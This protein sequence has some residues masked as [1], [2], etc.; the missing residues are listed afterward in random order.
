[1]PSETAAVRLFQL[2]LKTRTG[3][4]LNVL[5]GK[6]KALKKYCDRLLAKINN[7]RGS[8]Y[9]EMRNNIGLLI[10]NEK[11]RDIYAA[12]LLSRANKISDVFI[13]G[14][15]G[16]GKSHLLYK[17]AEEAI[18]TCTETNTYRIPILIELYKDGYK[19]IEDNFIQFITYPIFHLLYPEEQY[20]DSFTRIAYENW[21]QDL[22]NQGRLII[23]IDNYDEVVGTNNI[24]I[25]L[26]NLSNAN[27]SLKEYKNTII[28]STKP[29]AINYGSGYL[30]GF[31]R[32]TL[33]ELSREEIIK[34]INSGTH[35]DEN[36]IRKLLED[37][38]NIANLAKLPLALELIRE[39]MCE[40]ILASELQS[41]GKALLEYF[42]S[43]RNIG[44]LVDNSL[45]RRI[46]KLMLPD[47]ADRIAWDF[48]SEIAMVFA[49]SRIH[50]WDS[51]VRNNKI[52]EIESTYKKKNEQIS[53]HLFDKHNILIRNSTPLR[54]SYDVY[55][56]Y[57][58]AHGLLMTGVKPD[59]VKKYFEYP[60]NESLVFL[61]GLF[62]EKH[63]FK[64][65]L[66]LIIETTNELLITEC[67]LASNFHE[68]YEHYVL[69]KILERIGAEFYHFQCLDALRKLGNQAIEFI[70]AR[71][72]GASNNEKRRIA[73]FLGLSGNLIYDNIISDLRGDDVHLKYHI[74]RVIG[75]F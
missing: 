72:D 45:R 13:S 17:M 70:K 18:N 47:G 29:F 41:S 60:N 61:S 2:L 33:A 39:K 9:C 15:S 55:E 54:F 31:K 30:K 5:F 44:E 27:Y 22:F 59:D 68:E 4:A 7:Q 21:I 65:F 35:L 56:K 63:E 62:R 52:E 73:Y 28:I 40:V 37:L 11:N 64:N 42:S 6:K 14:H 48:L 67:L 57:L 38:P 50:N 32:F 3:R 49:D 26:Q 23:L 75:D 58:V 36:S 46:A 66:D 10:D 43:L 53:V 24:E 74:I 20:L 69:Q 12:D 34:Y 16:R 8:N 19:G 71:Y 25:L 51:N 1:M